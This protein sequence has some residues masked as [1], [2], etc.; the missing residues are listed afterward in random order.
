M[1]SKKLSLRS[2]QNQN[3]SGQLFYRCF[4][5]LRWSYMVIHKLLEVLQFKMF[6]VGVFH[7]IQTKYLFSKK[8]PDL[9]WA[10][11]KILITIKKLVTF[12]PTKF[13]NSPESENKA[14]AK[15]PAKIFET[16]SCFYVKQK[17]SFWVENWALGYSSKKF[18]DFLYIS[19]FLKSSVIRQ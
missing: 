7:F 12:F 11:G 17:S 14:K 18:R 13:C 3:F 10:E 4:W 1:N 9:I 15:I 6:C 19:W 8:K 16:N 2:F 5:W